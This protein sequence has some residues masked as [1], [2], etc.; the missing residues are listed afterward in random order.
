MEQLLHLKNEISEIRRIN[1]LICKIANRHHIS[2]AVKGD[3]QLA[4]EEILS[5]IIFYGYDDDDQHL[6]DICIR[7]TDKNLL[8]AIIDDA[9]PF[10]PV[11]VPEP[12]LNSSLECREIGGMGIHLVRNLMD[13]L[14]YKNEKGKNILVMK[15]YL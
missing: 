12:D 3:I 14:T 5:N 7:W 10:N 9:R 11:K 4:L 8:M 2:D 15:K 6:I 13:E 1:D